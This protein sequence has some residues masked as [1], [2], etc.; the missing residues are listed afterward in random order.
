MN[1]LTALL[2]LPQSPLNL[3]AFELTQR[4]NSAARA[5]NLKNSSGL[6]IKFADIH[7]AGA[8]DYESSVFEQGIVPTRMQSA[9]FNSTNSTSSISTNSINTTDVWHDYLNALMWF[10]WPKTKAALNAAQHAAMV[11]NQ[12]R[13]AANRKLHTNARGS[14]RDRLTLLDE[15]GVVV[16]CSPEMNEVFK[17]RAW[18]SLFL[19]HATAI[20]NGDFSVYIIGHGLLQ[21]LQAPYKAITGHCWVFEMR[22]GQLPSQPLADSLLSGEA[23]ALAVPRPLPLMGLPGW[24]KSWF[25]G[26]QDEAFYNDVKVFRQQ[27]HRVIHPLGDQI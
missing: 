5:V 19:D 11:L 15:S 27:R 10:C 12:G 16:M 1:V 22:N 25:A 4:L 26:Q 7:T 21:R 2:G 13:S 17:S 24:H 9:G 6:Q 14:V 23:H 20:E 18:T 8:I 3:T